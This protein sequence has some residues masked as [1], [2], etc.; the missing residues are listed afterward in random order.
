[1][2]SGTLNRYVDAP[3]FIFITLTSTTLQSNFY[4]QIRNFVID[5]TGTDQG[6]YIAAL[7]W[8]VAQATSLL[9]I[10]FISTTSASTT[11]QG[12]CM[13]TPLFISFI[14]LAPY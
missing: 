1:V 3:K 2:L 9:N 8:Q 4:R 14:A 7:H 13:S 6:A 5:I 10:N 11:K 12:I